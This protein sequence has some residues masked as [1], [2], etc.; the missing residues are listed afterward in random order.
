MKST[1]PRL[2]LFFLVAN[3]TFR[4]VGTTS[5]EPVLGD[6]VTRLKACGAVKQS[7]ANLHFRRIGNSVSHAG[8][9]HLVMASNASQV[10]HQTLTAC[11]LVMELKSEGFY[12][13]L[14]KIESKRNEHGF[15]TVTNQTSIARYMD[16]TLHNMN[17]RCL[18][19]IERVTD[20]LEMFWN[21]YSTE[22]DESAL[23]KHKKGVFAAQLEYAK[24]YRGQV[25]LTKAKENKLLEES[26]VG[27]KQ[28]EGRDRNKKEI[29]DTTY[30]TNIPGEVEWLG[31]K[32]A[33]DEVI[34][35]TQNGTLL[36]N[37][38][39]WP[40]GDPRYTVEWWLTRQLRGLWPTYPL[41]PSEKYLPRSAPGKIDFTGWTVIRDGVSD[42]LHA[43]N[44][45]ERRRL[46]RLAKRNKKHNLNKRQI[47]VGLI[48]AVV[49]IGSA[50]YSN[51]EVES[52]IDTAN[53][54]VDS[55]IEI[56][57]D[58]NHR[59]AVAENSINLLTDSL[60]IVKDNLQVFGAK[61]T[62]DEAILEAH[63]TLDAFYTEVERV[64]DGYEV[65]SRGYLSPSLVKVKPTMQRMIDIK[66]KLTRKGYTLGVKDF[67][68]IYSLPCSH[69]IYED[70]RAYAILHLPVFKDDNS[71]QL[72]SYDPLPYVDHGENAFTITAEN[73]LI[74]VSPDETRHVLMSYND[75]DKCTSVG[76]TKVCPNNNIV[77][78]QDRKSCLAS[79]FKGD[80]ETARSLCKYRLMANQ[81]YVTQTE[82]NSFLL[83]AL[84]DTTVKFVCKDEQNQVSKRV[85]VSGAHAIQ[86]QSDC[87]AYTSEHELEGQLSFAASIKGYE[88]RPLNLTEL[89][90][91][92]DEPFNADD[93]KALTGM[94]YEMGQDIT[95]ESVAS[96]FKHFQRKGIFSWF[97]SI[98]SYLSLGAMCIGGVV[99]LC[100]LV[101]FLPPLL[102]CCRDISGPSKSKVEPSSRR[103]STASASAS[104]RFHR[105]P[106]VISFFQRQ[107]KRH[108][109]TGS[110]T[111]ALSVARQIAITSPEEAREFL[112]ELLASDSRFDAAQ[113]KELHRIIML[114]E[115]LGAHD[116]D[117]VD[118]S[119][120]AAGPSGPPAVEET[121]I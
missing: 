113:V 38:E 118:L 52:I 116:I 12:R 96:R 121:K 36:W 33:M 22:G 76:D 58:H 85:T 108:S 62:A 82:P 15:N 70:G 5:F 112:T 80:L 17:S 1:I 72:Y 104:V 46:M 7:P 23:S 56:L 92:D 75:L 13:T 117:D 77:N 34:D 51:Y 109:T 42:A 30:A 107:R 37:D 31:L 106:S 57:D 90:S 60:D 68:E 10:A 20:S 40:E 83:Y 49:A 14:A 39:P 28:L 32:L 78:K 11:T 19:L 21:S 55:D 66:A 93:I 53:A 79:L 74:S 100:L 102:N 2:V 59:L 120:A 110:R 69:A 71:F 119:G 16:R 24:K 101:A 105:S 73:D 47:I 44:R 43:K 91:T 111:S 97:D 114:G 45:K 87:V 86:V 84:K 29:N 6:A 54:N 67:N 27:K 3:S 18:S 50:L 41:V 81:E 64:L 61:L 103:R 65:L 89:F 26:G 99:I 35:W 98:S 8:Y 48:A 115:Q 9:V 25:K 95:V 63:V 94:G 88:V 4:I